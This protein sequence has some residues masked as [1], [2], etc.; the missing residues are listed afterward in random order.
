MKKKKKRKIK[1]Q[2]VILNQRN[3]NKYENAK[4]V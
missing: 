1:I 2:L 4:Y 3:G